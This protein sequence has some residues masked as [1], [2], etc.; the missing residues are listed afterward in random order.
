MVDPPCIHKSTEMGKK[1]IF[2]HKAFS[3]S[4]KSTL[5][6]LQHIL[7]SQVKLHSVDRKLCLST[8]F[9]LCIFKRLAQS[10]CKM[11]VDFAS[12]YFRMDDPVP[13]DISEFPY[14]PD[15]VVRIVF[16]YCF[17]MLVVMFLSFHFFVYKILS[18]RRTISHT[19]LHVSDQ[20]FNLYIFIKF[21]YFPLVGLMCVHNNNILNEFSSWQQ[22]PVTRNPYRMRTYIS[23]NRVVV[24]IKRRL[25]S[26]FYDD[27]D[28][29]N[30]NDTHSREL[31]CVY[32]L[33]FSTYD[34]GDMCS[35][36][37]HN[38]YMNYITARSCHQIFTCQ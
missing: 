30:E 33:F 18:P 10:N 13:H 19:C 27:D 8:L 21:C 4:R 7:Y 9:L 29:M 36:Y 3:I 14:K 38:H 15:T 23:Q 31:L 28:V 32:M 20:K 35:N 22:L 6:K 25:A 24:D 2:H 26:T 11:F 1:L 34:M 5:Q 37:P 16:Y 17:R 12:L